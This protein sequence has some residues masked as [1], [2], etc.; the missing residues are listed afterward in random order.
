MKY[1][2]EHSL[3]YNDATYPFTDDW[4]IRY[5][6]VL[7]SYWVYDSHIWFFANL[8]STDI[9]FIFEILFSFSGRN[10]EISSNLTW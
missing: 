2:F 10:C 5:L 4:F 1:L 3:W 7:L 6:Y 8:D 9:G